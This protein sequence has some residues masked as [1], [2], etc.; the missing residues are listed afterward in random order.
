MSG[1]AP[2]AGRTFLVTG[3]TDA[4]SLATAVAA[5]LVRRGAHVVCSALGPTP[6]HEGL[7]ARARDHLAATLESCRKTVEREVG[8]GAETIAC[9]LTIDAS[10]RDLG[11]AL[12]RRGVALDGVVHAVARDRTLARGGAPGLLDVSREDFL[13]CLDVSA[14]SLI[15]LLRELLEAGALARGASAI[16]LSYLAAERVVT[17]PYAAMSVAKA[18]LERITLELA[19]ELGR[20]HGVRV[21]A[22]RFSPYTASRAGGSIRGLAQAEAHGAAIAP[23]GNALFEDLAREVAHL[24]TPGLAVTGEIRNVDGGLHLLASG[25]WDPAARRPGDGDRSNR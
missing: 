18:A 8:G 22:V 11:E 20:R 10:I 24:L 13:D 25:P 9:D 16:S 7:S 15:A 14:Y 12:G 23:L 19:A 1:A 6:H 3:I 21:N 5:E 2:L 4:A 17:H